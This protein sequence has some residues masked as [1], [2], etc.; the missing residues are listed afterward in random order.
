[1][2]RV[3]VRALLGE[4]ITAL[5]QERTH[6]EPHTVDECEGVLQLLW[7]RVAGVGVVPFERGH[8]GKR[9]LSLQPLSAALWNVGAWG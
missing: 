8:P 5:L 6:G 9:R 1:M 3:G 2:K 4:E 7:V